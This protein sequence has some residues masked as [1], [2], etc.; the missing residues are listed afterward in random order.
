L[1]SIRG[2]LYIH[3]RSLIGE[4]Q[5]RLFLIERA[6]SYLPANFHWNVV[7]LEKESVSFL[8]YPAFDMEGHPALEKSFKVN[9]S[10]KQSRIYV[11]SR[12]NPPI[13]HRKETL[14]KENDE[15]YQTFHQLTI[16]EEKAGLLEKGILHKIGHK[17]EWDK[18]LRNKGLIIEGHNLRRNP[19][20]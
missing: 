10:K 19:N 4:G 15:F 9:L 12:D 5:E 18:V 6:Q 14:L 17:K 2:K 20:L 13:I 7:R 3:R 1:K 16:E 11:A 8:C